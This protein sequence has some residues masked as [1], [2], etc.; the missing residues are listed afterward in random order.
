MSKATDKAKKIFG[1]DTEVSSMRSGGTL[2]VYIGSGDELAKAKARDIKKAH[3]KGES[4]EVAGV[5]TWIT[6]KAVID[7]SK[8]GSD[9]FTW[10]KSGNRI[11]QTKILV[12]VDADGKRT[13]EVLGT[14]FKNYD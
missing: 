9:M 13:E 1:P 12:T 6:H 5:K 8:D 2:N 11:K 3:A 7:T 14:V 10:D 4:A